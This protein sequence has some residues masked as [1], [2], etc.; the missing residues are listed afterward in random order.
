MD[1][2]SGEIK[3][4]FENRKHESIQ[5][6]PFTSIETEVEKRVD[7]FT[8]EKIDKNSCNKVTGDPVTLLCDN[9][10]YTGGASLKCEQVFMCGTTTVDIEPSLSI[11]T[12]QIYV[13]KT[14]KLV[15]LREKAPNGRNGANPGENGGDGESGKNA[16]NI[17]ISANQLMISSAKLLT[18]ESKGGDAGNGGDGANYFPHPNFPTFTFTAYDVATRGTKTGESPVKCRNQ[19]CGWDTCNLYS[20]YEYFKYE[21]YASYCGGKGGNPGKGGLHGE[22]TIAGPSG[23]TANSMGV[24]GKEGVPGKKGD[25]ERIEQLAEARQ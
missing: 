10:G 22:L 24:D 3:P 9:N 23:L 11:T 14:A 19:N 4:F 5:L 1:T 18:F 21:Y 8:K 25:G 16:A 20:H 2:L 15:S 12:N 13:D 6:F 17:M 7:V